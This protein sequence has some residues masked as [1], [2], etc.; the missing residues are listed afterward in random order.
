MFWWTLPAFAFDRDVVTLV[1]APYDSDLGFAGA[2][3]L[4][5][6]ERSGAEVAVTLDL[7]GAGGLTRHAFGAQPLQT[8]LADD[9]A[10]DTRA[11]RDFFAW[12]A[13]R[14]EAER[15]VVAVLDHG[16]R[17]GELA[18]DDH[19]AGWLGTDE[20]GEALRAFD[21]SERGRVGLVVLQVCGKGTLEAAWGLRG[22]ADE[23]LASA[24]VI[25]APNTWFAAFGPGPL[26]PQVVARM[27]SDTW[28]R[29]SCV[30]LRAASELPARLGPVSPLSVDTDALAEHTWT[31]AGDAF[32]DLAHVPLPRTLRAGP[33]S[34]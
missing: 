25:A 10:T 24:T 22:A 15:Y 3:I 21:A 12:A 16:G 11:L 27:P 18:R 28:M 31:Y 14:Y 4:A 29:W 13:E 30:D 6:A 34:T 17:V 9:D 8:T 7:P 20:L 5:A 23:L 19:P 26:A 1:W 33:T 32:V 2:E